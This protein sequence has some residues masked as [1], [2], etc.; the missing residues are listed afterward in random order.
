MFT[1]GFFAA[2]RLGV[3]NI[4][5]QDMRILIRWIGAVTLLLVADRSGGS[6]SAAGFYVGSSSGHPSAS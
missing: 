6:T 5:D 3:T 1:V 2:W 4:L